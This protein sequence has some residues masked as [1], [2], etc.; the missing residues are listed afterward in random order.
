MCSPYQRL[1]IFSELAASTKS[2]AKTRCKSLE[3]GLEL[4]KMNL[5]TRTCL[6]SLEDYENHQKEDHFTNR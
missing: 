4:K 2:S 1:Y 3:L 5:R 6:K